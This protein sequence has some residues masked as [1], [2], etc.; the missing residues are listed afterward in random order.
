MRDVSFG[1]VSSLIGLASK[2][3]PFGISI[4]EYVQNHWRG[5]Q[6]L[7]LSFW[8]NLAILRTAVL[9]MEGFILSPFVDSAY[10]GAIAA[11]AFFIVAH[12][13]VYIWQVVGVIRACDKYQSSYGSIS[14][15]WTIQFGIVIS[16]IF[17]FMSVFMSAQSVFIE[18]DKEILSFLW[19]RERAAKYALTLSDDEAF[20]L[21]NG[22]FELGITKNL[23]A[24]LKRHP[25]VTGIV[26]ASPGGN[27]YEGRGVAKIIRDH[28]LNSYVFADC[29]SACTLAFI[30]GERRI[31]GPNGKLGFHQYGLDADYQVPFVDIAEEQNADRE[32]FRLQKIKESFLEKVFDASH[33]YLWIP[34]MKEL[35]EG[36]VV[37]RVAAKPTED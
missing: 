32:T 34:S 13:I 19:E 14:V 5:E 15:I 2:I 21:L 35:L 27:T 23:A 8:V 37:H 26:L 12:V 17:T 16:L 22:S 18:R 7:A 24:F 31:M 20:L 1:A 11:L 30:A 36:G 9:S 4:K 25:N 29:F 10:A 28:R 6:S 33:G 3:V